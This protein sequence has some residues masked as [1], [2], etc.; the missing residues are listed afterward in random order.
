MSEQER[1]RESEHIFTFFL[2]FI[3]P[4]VLNTPDGF[5]KY[6]FELPTEDSG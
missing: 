4:R 3:A 1:K 6:R 5:K 2:G